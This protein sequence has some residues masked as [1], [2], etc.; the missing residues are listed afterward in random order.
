[1][2]DLKIV[3]GS[4]N[5]NHTPQFLM[6]FSVFYPFEI[7]SDLTENELYIIKPDQIL[8]PENLTVWIWDS[9]TGPGRTGPGPWFG[10]GGNEKGRK[11]K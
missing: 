9:G 8:D 7:G 6:R 4:D 1:M 5:E 11:K 3:T 10:P 2:I